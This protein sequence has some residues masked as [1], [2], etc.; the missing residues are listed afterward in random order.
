MSASQGIQGV[1]GS[2]FEAAALSTLLQVGVVIVIALIVYALAGKS[3]GKFAPFTGLT[4]TTST[5]AILGLLAGIAG[6]AVAEYIPGLRE[7]AASPNSV[8]GKVISAGVTDQAIA[9]L[10]LYALIKTSFA[11][12]LLFRGIIGKRLIARFG[13]QIGNL[14]QALAF[15]AIHLLIFLSPEVRASSLRPEY[16]LAF[17]A[18]FGWLSGFINEKFGGGSI[19]PGWIS[20][21]TANLAAYLGIAFAISWRSLIE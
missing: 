5:G 16:I 6:I 9:I 14:L 12:E 3:R 7:A 20:H 1:M 8:V 10:V 13:F 19:L 4:A 2:E 15:G 17:P 18:F 21:A 11:E